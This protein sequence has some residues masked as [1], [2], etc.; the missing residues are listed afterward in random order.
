MILA[1][2]NV[3]TMCSS[4]DHDILTAVI[5]RQI[6]VQGLDD[7]VLVEAVDHEAVLWARHLAWSSDSDVRS[8]GDDGCDWVDHDNED[9]AVKLLADD[10]SLH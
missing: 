9:I 10:S 1:V 7:Y 2:G 6:R 4:V 8:Q 3:S 5:V